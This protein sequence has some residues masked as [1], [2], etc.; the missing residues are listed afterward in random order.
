MALPG[1]TSSTRGA[2]ARPPETSSSVGPSADWPVQATDSIV[3]VVDSVRDKTTGPVLNATRWVIYGLVLA[4]LA[5][6]VAVLLLVGVMRL[7]EGL[8]LLVGQHFEWSW[9]HDPMWIVY[10]FYGGIFTLVGLVLWGKA[11]RVGV[12]A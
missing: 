12:P 10:L 5:V 8:L 6:P 4:L 1:I 3:R 11:D 2:A 9:L 7:S